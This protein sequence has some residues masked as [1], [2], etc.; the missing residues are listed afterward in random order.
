MWHRLHWW[1][2]FWAVLQWYVDSAHVIAH[3]FIVFRAGV[4]RPGWHRED[5]V[6]NILFLLY[7]YTC[8]QAQQTFADNLHWASYRLLFIGYL[9]LTVD[10]WIWLSCLIKAIEVQFGDVKLLFLLS[11]RTQWKPGSN[12]ILLYWIMSPFFHFK[13]LDSCIALIGKPG[14]VQVRQGAFSN[15]MAFLFLGL[16]ALDIVRGAIILELFWKFR[17]SEFCRRL[18]FGSLDF[19]G[20]PILVFSGLSCLIEEESSISTGA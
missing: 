15:F 1:C 9:A 11:R 2:L 18:L 19:L 14:H 6:S 20:V 4:V 17:Y 3:I 12:S 5:F 7:G 10:R 8:K 16:Q 13:I